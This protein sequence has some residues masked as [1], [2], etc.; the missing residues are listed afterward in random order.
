MDY[1]DLV[2]DVSIR[3]RWHIGELLDTDGREP[4]LFSGAP[5]CDGRSHYGLRRY[6][7]LRVRAR[8]GC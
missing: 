7:V 6:G 1:F 3:G 2:D 8:A 5:C 4:M